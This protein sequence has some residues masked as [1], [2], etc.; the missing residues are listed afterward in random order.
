MSKVLVDRGLLE[1]LVDHSRGLSPDEWKAAIALV[2]HPAEAVGVSGK[3]EISCWQC[4]EM[5]SLEV[6]KE[7]D[8]CC[9][10]CGV[11]IDLEA[12]LIEAMDKH[13][14]LRADLSAVTAER[15]Q[16]RQQGGSADWA[17]AL[18]QVAVVLEALRSSD[19]AARL[20]HMDAGKVL[21]EA[22]QKLRN[23]RSQAKQLTALPK[24]WKAVP[25][26]PTSE[27]TWAAV[28]AGGWCMADLVKWRAILAAVPALPGTP[29]QLTQE[30]A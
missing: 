13:V 29:N 15:D 25:E 9:C 4:H 20:A 5:T 12:Y 26:E 27:M 28:K 10:A 1:K 22:Y 7:F 2:T 11:E 21:G 30:D 3:H 17:D 16:L 8:G 23:I 14:E 19:S 18:L 6:R 24:G